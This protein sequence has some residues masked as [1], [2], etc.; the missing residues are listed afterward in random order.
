MKY[1]NLKQLKKDF[2]NIKRGV[3][4]YED[5]GTGLSFERTSKGYRMVVPT[6]VT[7]KAR[8]EIKNIKKFQQQ[9]T[10]LKGKVFAKDI[11]ELEREIESVIT[12]VQ[13]FN[14]GEI[15]RPQTVMRHVK[16]AETSITETAEYFTPENVET[17]VSTAKIQ[18]KI[19]YARFRG[20]HGVNNQKAYDDMI[21]KTSNWLGISEEDATTLLFPS[22]AEEKSKY[23]DFERMKQTSNDTI[24]GML[25]ARV[26]SGEIKTRDRT[27]AKK[28]LGLT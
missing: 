7:T 16:A 26:K 17:V 18:N 28:L 11:G 25:N 10:N 3:A 19:M 8:Q 1:K 20:K 13:K 15:K 9:Q 12:E 22:G 4:Y 2:P 23:E 6:G 24:M 27:N 5:V 21:K 14:K